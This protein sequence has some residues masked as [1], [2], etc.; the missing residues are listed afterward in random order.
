M[1]ELTE[2]IKERYFRKGSNAETKDLMQR[3]RVKNAIQN[4]CDSKITGPDEVLEFEISPKDLPYATEVI[5]E[6][7]LK[8]KYDIIQT[9]ETLFM[10][11]LRVL[12][13]G[14]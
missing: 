5:V 3:Q 13:I 6:E 1:G 9:S 8:S 11:Q 14:L 2:Y 12:D 4:I 7:P 10:A